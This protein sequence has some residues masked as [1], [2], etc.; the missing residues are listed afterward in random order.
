[1]IGENRKKFF[2]LGQTLGEIIASYF[3]NPTLLRVVRIARVGR[4]LRLVKGAKGI[5][6]LLFAL[7]VSM[8]ALFNIGL[9]L[10]LVMF[11]YSIFGMSFFS[12]V[13]KAAGVTEVFNFE[14]FPNSLIIL[15]QMCTTAG[16]SGV[17]QALT[18]DRP[19]D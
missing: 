11:I 13:R 8:P 9:L 5:R 16:W 1:M 10:F 18:S 14:T 15:F 7:A 17:L 19:P 4:I 12:Y 3:V 6:T 2:F